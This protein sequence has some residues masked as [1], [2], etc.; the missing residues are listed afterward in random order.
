MFVLLAYCK[1][2]CITG[3]EVPKGEYKFSST[4][5]LREGGLLLIVGN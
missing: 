2:C 1:V 3:H 5:A 4:L